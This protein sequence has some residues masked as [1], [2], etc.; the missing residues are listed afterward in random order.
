MLSG[1][2]AARATVAPKVRGTIARAPLA[3]AV[4]SRKR[5]RV[6]AIEDLKS[7]FRS[8]GSGVKI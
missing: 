3:A 5:R 7:G 1:F 4:V 8:Q 6:I 2:P